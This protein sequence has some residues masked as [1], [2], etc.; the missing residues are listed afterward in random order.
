[1]NDTTEVEKRIAALEAELP[2]EDEEITGGGA[3]GTI[4]AAVG[5][6]LNVAAAV[7]CMDNDA[8]FSVSG[9]LR[10]L[11]AHSVGE[12]HKTIGILRKAHGGVYELRDALINLDEGVEEDVEKHE[13]AVREALEKCAKPSVDGQPSLPEDMIACIEAVLDHLPAG[14]DADW[15]TSRHR[16]ALCYLIARVEGVYFFN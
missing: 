7:S 9:V 14:R 6:M 16:K 15:D 2:G 10:G 12:A 11:A 3:V 1:M 8:G 13:A 4:N 5:V